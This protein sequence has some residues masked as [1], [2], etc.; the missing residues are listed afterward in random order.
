MALQR[1]QNLHATITEICTISGIPGLSYGVIHNGEVLPKENFGYGDLDSRTPVTSDTAYYIGSLS[2]AFTT[3]AMGILLEDKE[4]AWDSLVSNVMGEGFHFSDSALTQEMTIRDVLA[5]KMGLQRSNQLWCGSD[6]VLLLNKND[7]IPHIQSLS[8]VQPFRS[9]VHYNNWGYV[10]AGEMIEKVSG[11]SWGTFVE[12]N[13]LD[14]LEMNS[15]STT[16]ISKNSKLANPYS[17]LDNCFFQQL[18]PISIE[19]GTIMCSGASIQST[20]N[21]MLRWCKALNTAYNDQPGKRNHSTPGSPLKQIPEQMAGL[22]PV[23]KPF[24]SGSAFGMGWVR[25]QLPTVLG[26]VGCNPGFVKNMPAAGHGNKK[27]VIYHQGSMARY[28]SSLYL[29]RNTESGVIVLSNSISL[30]DC[31][32]WVGQTILEALIDVKKPN[33]YIK[34]A[35][36]SAAAHI[37]KFPSMRASLEKKR[38]RNTNHKKPEA[39]LGMYYN[40]IRDFCIKIRKNEESQGLELAFQGLD[41]QV[42]HMEHYHFDTFLWL[43]TRDEAVRR[44]RFT[45]N[46]ETLYK[47]EFVTNEQGEVD[48]L[49]WAYDA[50][51]P[52]EKFYRDV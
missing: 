38:I 20:V 40:R 46:P 52:A 9:T 29:I 12:R 4:T 1:L 50:E 28:T 49:M 19:D 18:P 34:Y 11:I 13:L 14:P 37:A 39:Y 10:L 47:L 41:S 45:Y 48:S 15:T 32:D 31:A 33:K 51:G 21:D 44:G 5:H 25:A 6:N 42:W 30:N 16:K 27:L 23:A 24:D 17:V 43:M 22:T 8:A 2:K 7:V 36:E 26:A 35:Q 3:A